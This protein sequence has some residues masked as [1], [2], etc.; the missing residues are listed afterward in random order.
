MQSFSQ[1]RR[2]RRRLRLEHESK[3]EK[4]IAVSRSIENSR[5][6]SFLATPQISS[7]DIEKASD[8]SPNLE[9][10]ASK[11]GFSYRDLILARSIEGVTV[12][13]HSDT[14][15]DDETVF[16]VDAGN[17]NELNPQKWT[18][19]SRIWTMC[20]LSICSFTCRFF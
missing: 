16:V 5:H 4:L 6:S 11:P 1:Y 9:V 2:L 18:R 10:S 17:E 19:S 15:M 7:K 3:H 12:R 14:R 20:V 13:N 8:S